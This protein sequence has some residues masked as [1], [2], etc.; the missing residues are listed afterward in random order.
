MSSR[1]WQSTAMGTAP[2]GA[3][4]GQGRGWHPVPA[5]GGV[6]CQG[7]SGSQCQPSSD[8]HVKG[9]PGPVPRP[10]PSRGDRDTL[11]V[12]V[13]QPPTRRVWAVMVTVTCDR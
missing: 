5:G 11:G 7:L 13:R 1:F 10:G 8:R 6:R 4:A 9:P 3:P 2:R 12:T